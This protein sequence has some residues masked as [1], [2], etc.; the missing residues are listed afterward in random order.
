MLAPELVERYGAEV[1]DRTEPEHDDQDH[2]GGDDEDDGGDDALMRQDGWSACQT[3]AR[4]VSL[5]CHGKYP[6]VPFRHSFHAAVR[7]CKKFTSTEI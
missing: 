7:R 5:I 6:V 4:Q 2:H 1:G 3:S